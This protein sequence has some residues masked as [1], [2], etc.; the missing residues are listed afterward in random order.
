MLAQAEGRH[1]EAVHELRA[2]AELED[3]MEKHPVT[4]GSIVPLHE[5][6]GD[7]LFEL[8]QPD[9]ALAEYERSLTGAP[10]R[11]RTVYGAAKAADA[12]GNPA[13]AKRYF[14]QLAQLATKAET[15]RPELAEA[16]AYLAR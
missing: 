16:T 3:A 5:L 2:A 14:Q 1:D 4:P 15:A 6:L 12:S 13:E 11:F 9:A 8:G 10:N 7:L